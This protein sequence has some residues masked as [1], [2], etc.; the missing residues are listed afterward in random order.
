MLACSG[1]SGAQSDGAA[2]RLDLTR[3][4]LPPAPAL[5]TAETDWAVC[6]AHE[7]LHAP[8]HSRA[9]PTHLAL[10]PLA[11]DHLDPE[12]AACRFQYSRVFG[13]C[14][15]IFDLDTAAN[16]LDRTPVALN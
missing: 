3:P 15:A 9:D 12:A 10:S 1:R 16:T 7:P 11:Q 8:T 14:R 2:Q 6:H 13:S 5:E 4:Q